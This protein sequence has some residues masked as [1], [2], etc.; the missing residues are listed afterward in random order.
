ME[1]DF[2]GWHTKKAQ[3]ESSYHSPY[4]YEREIWWCSIG[5][6]VGTEEDGKRDQ[7][8][9]PVIVFRKFNK[10]LLWGLPMSSHTKRSNHYFP[11]LFRGKERSIL[12][13]QIRVLSAKRLVNRMGKMEGMDFRR[14]D[15]MFSALLK[16]TDPLRGLRGL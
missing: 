9:R 12:L 16:Q 3:I 6:N 10:D 15:E 8:H 5:L 13:S 2:F 11:F 1:K 14:L 7:F 4:F